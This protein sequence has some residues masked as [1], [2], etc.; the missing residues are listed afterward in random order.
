MVR[1]GEAVNVLRWVWEEGV[2]EVGFGLRI[3]AP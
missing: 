1:M 2:D 3:K